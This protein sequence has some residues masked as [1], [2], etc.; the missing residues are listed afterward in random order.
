MVNPRTFGKKGLGGKKAVSAAAIP[1]ARISVAAPENSGPSI[2]WPTEH[3][4]ALDEELRHWKRTRTQGFR[5]PW[6]QIS[7]MASLCFGG[8]SFV[9]PASVNDAMSLPLY[10]LAA[11]SFW[12]GIRHKKSER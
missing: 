10:A 6:R 11:I 7:L 3:N 1:A 4:A 2:A 9:L 12:T 8:A 5:M